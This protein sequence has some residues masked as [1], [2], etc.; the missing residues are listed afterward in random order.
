MRL[1]RRKLILGCASVAAMTAGE[2]A[3]RPLK[4]AGARRGR[5]PAPVQKIAWTPAVTAAPADS[6]VVVT[7]A[8][9]LPRVALDPQGMVRKGLL[10]DALI[11][12]KRHG[13]RIP[14]KDHMYLVDFRLHSSKPRLFR[15]DLRTGEVEAFRTAHGK[16]SDPSRTGF[17]Q[18]FSNTPNSS[19]SSV[20]A[21]LTAGQSVGARDGEN[22]LLEGLDRTNSEA[23]ARAIIVHGA[24]Y[25][26]P[27]YLAHEGMLGRSNGCFALSHEDLKV[28]R[29]KM[30]S[31]RL[32]FAGL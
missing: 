28:L 19:A 22:V 16:G 1:H 8:P 29:P 11:A 12:L 2:S 13:D 5:K 24:D 17:A 30:D 26:E 3:A 18:R 14:N 10:D 21:Y 31:G 9:S 32:I 25:C 27:G 4:R 6:S 7:T 15:L 20:G 23:R